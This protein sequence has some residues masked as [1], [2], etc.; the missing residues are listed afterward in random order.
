MR[1]L[2]FLLRLHALP[3]LA[4]FSRTPRKP[5]LPLEVRYLIRPSEEVFLYLSN[6]SD[7]KT[8]GGLACHYLPLYAEAR[9]R[10]LYEY[11]SQENIVPPQTEQ[12]AFLQP[13]FLLL[14]ILSVFG[15]GCLVAARM[16][17]S[18]IN[19]HSFLT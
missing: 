11:P 16:A 13:I 1:N 4:R 18:I 12:Y 14:V 6:N 19:G 2:S 17:I 9:W 8:W 15:V 5:Y 3:P 10:P 7:N